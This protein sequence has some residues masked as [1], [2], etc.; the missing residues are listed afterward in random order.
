MAITLKD[1]QD[2]VFADVAGGST[3]TNPLVTMRINQAIIYLLNQQYAAGEFGEWRVKTRD[4]FLLLPP[5][6]E[7]AELITVCEQPTPINAQWYRYMRH[8]VPYQDFCRCQGMEVDDLGDGHVTDTELPCD[9]LIVAYSERPLGVDPPETVGQ[10]IY[11]QGKEENGRPVF[12]HHKG[13]AT[14]GIRLD[15]HDTKP[16][17]SAWEGR[18]VKLKTISH[19]HKPETVWPVTVAGYIPPDDPEDADDAAILTPLCTLMPWETSI[20][21]RL[22]KL[23]VRNA[24]EVQIFGRARYRPAKAPH[25]PLLIQNLEA[26]RQG[27]FKIEAETRGETNVASYHMQQAN[28]SIDKSLDRNNGATQ[29]PIYDFQLPEG[30]GLGTGLESL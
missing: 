27:V 16:R 9:Q 3:P 7:V 25:E 19:V 23:S 11:I 10:Q 28:M 12:S 15:I 20:S 4:G 24:T 13:A 8:R 5:D 18:E 6:I 29:T 30:Y 17:M 22:Y 1:A 2:H 14:N 21:R 26:I